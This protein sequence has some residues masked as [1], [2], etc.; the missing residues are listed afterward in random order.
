MDDVRRPIGEVG[1]ALWDGDVSTS[2]PREG[3]ALMVALA[4]TGRRRRW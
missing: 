3:T 2:S 4:V 1:Q